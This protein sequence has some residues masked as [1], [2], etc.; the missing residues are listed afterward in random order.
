MISLI[1]FNINSLKNFDTSETSKNIVLD[2][3][4]RGYIIY[5]VANGSVKD[6][7]REI[8]KLGCRGLM[9]THDSNDKILLKDH[10][11]QI[12]QE[13]DYNVREM[14]VIDSDYVDIC[15]ARKLGINVCLTSAVSFSSQC[16]LSSISYYQNENSG[17]CKKTPFQKNINIVIPIMGDNLRFKT[18]SYRTERNLIDMM[19]K[20]IFVWVINNLQIDANYIFIVREH[21]CRLHNFDKILQCI[22][23]NCTVIQ[24]EKKTEGNVGSILLAE[25][26]IDNNLPVIIINDNQWLN[27]DVETFIT[28]FLLKETA[29]LQII[30]F[31]SDGSNRYK[32]IQPD[33]D[34]KTVLYT[35]L[36]KQISEYALTEVYFWRTGKDF[37]RYTHKMTSR[38]QRILGELCT[39]LVANELFDEI[40]NGTAKKHSVIHRP[41]DDYFIFQ[42]PNDITVFENWYNE[43]TLN[44]RVN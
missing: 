23:P 30:T 21:L 41:C 42:D 36:D 35:S 39:T 17:V 6:L 13:N 20:P 34:N 18:S 11:L 31:V 22:V 1:L 29:L 12:I 2:L 25:R 24:S 15:I 3:K 26:F 43:F 4:N 27:W 8:N 16:I 33:Q 19:G 14:L 28:D 10:Y 37:I 5:G 7:N 44:P 40:N 38:N 32:Y 9:Q